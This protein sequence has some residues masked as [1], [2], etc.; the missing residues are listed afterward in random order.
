LPGASALL[1][2]AIAVE[3][4]RAGARRMLPLVD[5]PPEL[6]AVLRVLSRTSV[7]HQHTVI[8]REFTMPARSGTAAL[9][10]INALSAALAH[11]AA[12]S[13]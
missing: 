11:R 13:S 9:R 5:E 8:G 12:I 2:R 10:G 4:L 6:R 1:E 7:G 3:R